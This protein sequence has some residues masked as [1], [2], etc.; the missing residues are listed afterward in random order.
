MAEIK[1]LDV[2]FKWANDK[3]VRA[4]SFNQDHIDFDDHKEWFLA[5]IQSK[6]CYYYILEYENVSV[7][8]I[9]FDVEENKTAKISYLIDSNFTGM[10]LG[11]YLL[12][13]GVQV[14]K[15]DNSN[16]EKVYGF[17]L[18]DNKASV[19]IFEKLGYTHTINEDEIKFEKQLC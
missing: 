12:K 2:T 7:G 6:S 16:L 8:S 15:K 19:R 17:V 11:Y 5:K 10:G 3:Q 18:P 1:H 13:F 4:F 9:R 14:L